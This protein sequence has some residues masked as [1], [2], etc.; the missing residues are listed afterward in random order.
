MQVGPDERTTEVN[1]VAGG[2]S[3]VGT[4]STSGLYTPPAN[5][6]SPSTVTITAISVADSTKSASAQV[7]ITAPP[8]GGGAMDWL[9]LIGLG[10][11]AGSSALRAR[12]A[13]DRRA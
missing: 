3:T 10:I 11:F 6:P 5:V 2:N 1:G 7:T 13:A 4:I 12:R 8:K 9:T